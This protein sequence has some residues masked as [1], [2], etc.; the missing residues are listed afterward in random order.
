MV[1]MI[2]MIY[3]SFLFVRYN[4]ESADSSTNTKSPQNNR[5]E[6]KIQKRTETLIN[7]QKQTETNRSKQKRTKTNRNGQRWTEP[8][9]CFKSPI[10]FGYATAGGLMKT[11]TKQKISS[12]SGN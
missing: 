6:Q 11:K 7:A 3:G 2:C 8:Y 9:S 12:Y 10:R 4:E 1:K 5:N